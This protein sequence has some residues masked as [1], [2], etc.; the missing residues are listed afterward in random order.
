MLRPDGEARDDGEGHQHEKGRATHDWG[1]RTIAD[2]LRRDCTRQ[3]D[4]V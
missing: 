3:T 2:L 4:G 1:G